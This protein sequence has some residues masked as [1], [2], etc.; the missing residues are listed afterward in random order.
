MSKND[1]LQATRFNNI[2]EII[3]N[4]VKL[5]PN[6][7][8]FVTKEKNENGVNYKN[9]T[10]RKM[11]DEINA[12][13][14][15]F[16]KLGL[17]GKR[18]AII[19]RNRYE[20][21]LAHISC[22]LGG[23]VSVPLDKDLQVNELEESL[24]RSKADAIVFDEK[25]KDKIEEVK[26]AG[27]TTTKYYISMSKI[28]GYNDLEELVSDGENIISSGNK[29][30]INA[31]IDEKGM[32][33]LLFTSGTTSK[34]KAVMLSQYGI[35][36]NIYDMLLV[37]GL[38]DK[39]TNIA[40]LPYHHVYGST[41]ILVML[42]KGVKTVFTDG[43]RYIQSNL[44]E[45]KVSV[46]VS[47]PLL[48]D[49]M[50]ANIQ[51]AIEKQNKTKLI[52]FATKISNILFKLHIDIRRK[53]FKQVIDELGGSLR[54]I[55]S[56]G[57]PLDEKTHKAFDDFGIHLVQGYGLTE[58]SPVIA[59]ENDKYSRRGSVGIPMKHVD[60]KIENKD[61]NGIGEIAV[62]GP[63]IMLGYYEN[64]EATNEVLKDG[65][66]YTGDLGY[67]DKD[68]F[69]FITGRRKDMIVL[70]NGKKVFPEEL[71]TLV[72]RLPEVEEC[73]VFG[74]P[75]D[76]DKNDL[77]V[78]I[79]I[80]YNKEEV[81]NIYGTIEEEELDEKIWQKI[82]EIN[83]TLPKYKYIKDMLLTDEELIKT[84]TKKIKRQEEM[85]KILNNKQ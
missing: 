46:F 75:E 68:G 16:Y 5:Y 83:K 8:A 42:A 37:E 36:S 26:N 15:T 1:F 28:D 51:K 41:A 34:S 13:G 10:Y 12:L 56:G 79:K 3:Y 82:K 76:D 50:Y 14:S 39:D 38:N 74:M 84:T 6:H 44:K 63:N 59:S 35:A 27:K 11:L 61:E 53:I 43:L 31:E 64:E 7:V 17:R 47:V 48:V 18:I 66:F 80:I 19:G 23:I 85:K 9:T 40:L 77:K 4:S 57:A 29:E 69:L 67:L 2:K 72:N 70:K 55:I 21:A 32:S 62:K 58:A 54:F 52:S 45:Y 71:E 73:M 78:S 81:K 60:V 24:I 22:L 30:Y 25:Y 33:I 65:W 20:W 49:K